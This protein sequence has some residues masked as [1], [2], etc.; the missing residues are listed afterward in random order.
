MKK[1][2]PAFWY[3]SLLLFLIV[4]CEN[5]PL[6]LPETKTLIEGTIRYSS[7]PAIEIIGYNYPATAIR[8]FGKQQL[9]SSGHFIL[10]FEISGP[11]QMF[12]GH[13]KTQAKMYV[14]PGDHLSIK[15]DGRGFIET[16]N[17]EGSEIN[18]YLSDKQRIKSAVEVKYNTTNGLLSSGSFLNKEEE[19]SVAQLDLF[20]DF[21][22]EYENDVFVKTENAVLVAEKYNRHYYYTIAYKTMEN[23][24]AISG[25]GDPEKPPFDAEY[26]LINRE[27]RIALSNYYVQ[28]VS[29]YSRQYGVEYPEATHQIYKTIDADDL[30]KGMKSY[31]LA[32]NLN[33]R[34]DYYGISGLSTDYENYLQSFPDSPYLKDLQSKYNALATLLPGQPA[35]DFVL[36]ERSGNKV[37]LK[38]LQGKVVYIDLW[39][40]WCKPCL[41]E[42]PAANALRKKFEGKDVAF[43][44]ISI[45]DDKEDWEKLLDKKPEFKGIQLIAESGWTSKIMTDYQIQGIPK[46]MLISKDGK[47]VTLEAKKPSSPEIEDQITALLN[48][49]GV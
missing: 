12:L 16:I 37:S 29:E 26:A 31:L 43:V 19:L 2:I 10:E 27:Y 5:E 30:E 7:D 8:E 13:M 21:S 28:K 9:D 46:Y 34:I 18:N 35:P 32:Y 17:F 3:I 41:V 39:A 14:Q 6:E 24:N 44:Y 25:T 40:S 4:S 42:I 1:S 48:R 38:E 36:E 47:I 11:T 45:D 22:N 20:E 33:N 15:A 23:A 49:S